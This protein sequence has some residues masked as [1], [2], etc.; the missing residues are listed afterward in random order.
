MQRC[1]ESITSAKLS[2]FNAQ[3]FNLHS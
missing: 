3:T 2:V 1:L